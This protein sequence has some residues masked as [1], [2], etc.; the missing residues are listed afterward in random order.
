M[1]VH[2]CI[3]GAVAVSNAFFGQGNGPILISRVQCSGSESSLLDCY[4]SASATS[5]CSHAEDAGV[6]CLGIPVVHFLKVSFTLYGL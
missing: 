2:A 6:T 1:H 5:S 3:A 4:W